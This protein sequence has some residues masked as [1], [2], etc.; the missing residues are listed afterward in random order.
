MG[1]WSML[2]LRAVRLSILF[3]SLIVCPKGWGASLSIYEVTQALEDSK[4]ESLFDLYGAQA[5]RDLMLQLSDDDLVDL[6]K[7][8]PKLF[9]QLQKRLIE[10][11]H[12]KDLPPILTFPDESESGNWKLSVLRES[13]N[14]PGNKAIKWFLDHH[15][16]PVDTNPA[17][18]IP[19]ELR[20]ITPTPWLSSATSLIQWGAILREIENFRIAQ[21]HRTQPL[22]PWYT[23]RRA[24]ALMHRL[25]GAFM[26]AALLKD[27]P[28]HI[29]GEA[30]R[31]G[32]R[33]HADQWIFTLDPKNGLIIEG[34]CEGKAS[35]LGYIYKAIY[36][37]H[38][39]IT[40]L[41]EPN[42][43]IE[44]YGHRVDR[45][46]IK[47]RTKKGLLS[48]TDVWTR[49][50]PRL[51]HRSIQRFPPA[52]SPP[53]A[54]DGRW[55][56]WVR[57]YGEL[58]RDDF[59]QVALPEEE[60]SIASQ[61]VQDRG[62]V[63]L[64]QKLSL[65][66]KCRDL[67]ERF[68]RFAEAVLP[69][70]GK[71][72]LYFALFKR[73]E[74]KR[75]LMLSYWLKP[76]A[77]VNAPEAAWLTYLREHRYAE[78]LLEIP[79]LESSYLPLFRPEQQRKLKFIL[80][81]LLPKFD[82]QILM[83][84]LGSFRPIS[85]SRN[86]L[87]LEPLPGEPTVVFR[88][89]DGVVD[90]PTWLPGQTR[91]ELWIPNDYVWGENASALI[92]PGLVGTDE[93]PYLADL[94]L[95][96]RRSEV[97]GQKFWPRPGL[98][99]LLS[100]FQKALDTP[101]AEPIRF[102]AQCPASYDT[103]WLL[104]RSVEALVSSPSQV[105]QERKIVLVISPLRRILAR[106]EHELSPHFVEH[107]ER[108]SILH[109]DSRGKPNGSLVDSTLSAA[110]N[111]S[112]KFQVVLTTWS[113]LNRVI[114]RL[115]DAQRKNFK[116][117]LG[118]VFLAQTEVAHQDE[119]QASM[120]LLLSEN[121]S[122]ILWG[123]D[124]LPL[125]P[126]LSTY[127]QGKLYCM[128]GDSISATATAETMFQQLATGV[129]EGS[130]T[131][132]KRSSAKHI[133]RYQS[134]RKLFREFTP[135]FD[136]D[137]NEIFGP[138]EDPVRRKA[139]YGFFF[140]KLKRFMASHRGTIRVGRTS[141]AK[142]LAAE[143][144]LLFNEEAI[145]TG[146]NRIRVAAIHKGVPN[147]KSL[148]ER[149]SNPHAADPIHWVVTSRFGDLKEMV[150]HTTGSILLIEKMEM[151][152]FALILD[153]LMGL[154]R[155]GNQEVSVFEIARK[156]TLPESLAEGL[157]HKMVQLAKPT[158]K[159]NP[160]DGDT[161]PTEI[162]AESPPETSQNLG[163]DPQIPVKVTPAEDEADE[164]PFF[165]EGQFTGVPEEKEDAIAFWLARLA[166]AAK[167]VE[168]KEPFV[169]EALIAIERLEALVGAGRFEN[170]RGYLAAKDKSTSV[171]HI[172]TAVFLPILRD[173]TL[174]PLTNPTD[175]PPSP[176]SGE[177]T[178]FL[179]R[180]LSGQVFYVEGP[181]KAT[182]R[183]M[184]FQSTFNEHIRSLWP[185]SPDEVRKRIGDLGLDHAH[186]SDTEACDLFV[187][188]WFGAL[189]VIEASLQE[190]RRIMVIKDH[191]P[192]LHKVPGTAFHRWEEQ[193]AVL[194]TLSPG[195]P[196]FSEVKQTL[197]WGTGSADA[198]Y[199]FIT[200][201][202]EVKKRME[203][204][205]P[206]PLST[207]PIAALWSSYLLDG[208]TSLE[209]RKRSINNMLE[210]CNPNQTNAPKFTVAQMEAIFGSNM[211][212]VLGSMNWRP[213]LVSYELYQIALRIRDQAEIM[214]NLD[215][216]MPIPYGFE[217]APPPVKH[218]SDLFV[219][220][221]GDNG[222]GEL[223]APQTVL[224]S[225]KNILLATSPKR[226]RYLREVYKELKPEQRTEF[227]NVC[228]TGMRFAI[229]KLMQ[230]IDETKTNMRLGNE[231]SALSEFI[232]K[233]CLLPIEKTRFGAD[234]FNRLD[235]ELYL[236]HWFFSRFH[237][238]ARIL[239]DS[240]P[241]QNQNELALNRL[242]GFVHPHHG[243]V[244]SGRLLRFDSSRGRVKGS[245]Y[246]PYV[247]TVSNLARN[248]KFTT[249]DL[250]T[251]KVEGALSAAFDAFLSEWTPSTSKDPMT[252]SPITKEEAIRR[253]KNMGIEVPAAA[254]HEEVEQLFTDQ[255][256]L[257]M[258]RL[259]LW[260]IQIWRLDEDSSNAFLSAYTK[261]LRDLIQDVN[262]L[263]GYRPEL[264]F[265][266]ALT[267]GFEEEPNGLKY[268]IHSLFIMI[269]H[270][271]RTS[272]SSEATFPGSLGST[273]QS[274]T[275]EK[276]SSL[277]RPNTFYE[278]IVEF[279]NRL[280]EE[281]PLANISIK[282]ILEDYPE[283][284]ELANMPGVTTAEQL[285]HTLA[286][287]LGILQKIQP[288]SRPW[289]ISDLPGP[290]IPGAIRGRGMIISETGWPPS[291]HDSEEIRVE[292]IFRRFWGLL[293]PERLRDI[294]A[295]LEQP[296]LTPEQITVLGL[297]ITLTKTEWKEI[298]TEMPDF[299]LFRFM[300]GTRPIKSV[301]DM[302]T[303]VK[304][305]GRL[306]K[307]LQTAMISCNELRYTT[308]EEREHA[309]PRL[310]PV[311]IALDPEMDSDLIHKPLMAG[312]IE[313]FDFTNP[314]LPLGR[315][316][317]KFF[318]TQTFFPSLRASPS[319]YVAITHLA[320][321]VRSLLARL[322]IPPA[323]ESCPVELSTAPD[324]KLE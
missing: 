262:H 251:E 255:I 77:E 76:R 167:F 133:T 222:G 299:E 115:N 2:F 47:I 159:P 32:G 249:H 63:T 134:P 221:P 271:I 70:V 56:E 291:P 79:K 39:F 126:V 74:E 94:D 31:I 132:L 179:I 181:K 214:P 86:T 207:P 8:Y 220:S 216:M 316:L 110:R 301:G 189:S 163:T 82:P 1:N 157:A 14:D 19:E 226:R 276:T 235:K 178:R 324:Q 295:A 98:F 200:A 313:N 288:I 183:L 106:I 27:T 11:L 83:R 146:C 172:E 78:L 223:S 294:I 321:D 268:E 125:S 103:H 71:T 306:S 108:A 29:P 89:I 44:I 320:G 20:A 140:K 217:E 171:Q 298:A 153:Q 286:E 144:D 201:Y 300:S 127:F 119:N 318:R 248:L 41:A 164:I 278:K 197:E 293:A 139:I 75:R 317:A 173:F 257:L 158:Q 310:I 213:E 34:F 129:A 190:L 273:I 135:D 51:R 284:Q 224:E 266:A 289:E 114:K 154:G 269:G 10:Q 147:E 302:K 297:E 211:H 169:H 73:H 48:L 270:F 292:K 54:F 170:F 209:D 101:N 93:N 237:K 118:A 239:D 46:Q 95:Q 234:R 240:I 21:K 42:A 194:D 177:N 84:R 252:R 25:Y 117:A 202:L 58:F 161:E 305:W 166:I 148:W 141:V 296:N 138:I 311:A 243:R 13:L 91:K 40:R 17:D 105:F 131:P 232:D 272:L 55:P 120:D 52:E 176:N 87:R 227:I 65:N 53:I 59:Y 67:E 180:N 85:V 267:D 192:G 195:D 12:A 99:P 7:L 72:D 174:V 130:L 260:S 90:V 277:G 128:G 315:V 186:L 279:T 24:R 231:I 261:Q 62:L 280:K 109:W 203:D 188:L 244:I 43:S 50:S 155:R 259:K 107:P 165:E 22:N 265:L 206:A 152:R 33:P 69:N 137:P 242:L 233:T 323:E 314:F 250:P 229:T 182:E 96:H 9:I 175:R 212:N 312:V 80:D 218:R 287:V 285:K 304:A 241:G 187:N 264:K 68:A 18:P 283:I 142:D 246:S 196:F 123:Q 198:I 219:L 308:P 319:S 97:F 116:E 35:V 290:P 122:P 307:R 64:D 193:L 184:P 230:S 112:Q 23:D 111:D 38:G 199:L 6:S 245:K 275:I 124:A 247:W 36:Q 256:E 210:R 104:T 30:I 208:K 254:P 57:F 281:L 61:V 274:W 150:P 322:K 113:Q 15:G 149:Y 49:M 204:A 121:L 168:G 88:W 151:S 191:S 309:E 228:V 215:E 102:Y 28:H 16:A 160:G 3:F 66:L 45:N 253:L 303:I 156:R 81:V 26:D 100:Q 205:Y 136:F 4:I 145:S 263:L 143:L 185:I 37:V 92:T 5:L 258:S 225:L 162:A 236:V 282:K 60:V 238:E